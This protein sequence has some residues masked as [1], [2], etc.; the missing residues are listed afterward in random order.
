MA[1][2]NGKTVI[3]DCEEAEYKTMP[4]AAK[5]YLKTTKN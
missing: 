2:L 5:K 4:L 3:Q 1:E